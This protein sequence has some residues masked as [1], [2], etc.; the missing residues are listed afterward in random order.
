MAFLAVDLGSESVKAAIFARPKVESGSD[1]FLRREKKDC[2]E[3][4]GLGRAG[5]NSNEVYAGAVIDPE[6]VSEKTRQAIR[7]AVMA[8]GL[9]PK[10][11]IFG[12]SGEAVKGFTTK[13]RLNRGEPKKPLGD[14]EIKSIIENINRAVNREVV[15]EMSSLSA[16]SPAEN[17]YETI[18][19]EMEEVTVDNY[20]INNPV[21]C[22]GEVVE[23]SL[24]TA[25]S[26]RNYFENFNRLAK[27]VKISDY[28]SLPAL[29]PLVKFLYADGRGEMNFL[30]ID[31]GGQITDLA[32]VFGG[33]LISS[34]TIN[35]GGYL[36]TRSIAE[37]LG[38]SPE[39][40]AEKKS[41]Y[42]AGKLGE[43]E[44]QKISEI[45]RLTAKLWCS[46]IEA[47]LLDF[48]EVRSF[49]DRIFIVGGGSALSE[50]AGGLA[51][52]P[53]PRSIAF[54]AAPKIKQLGPEI[55]EETL[56]NRTG[57]SFSPSDLLPLSLGYHFFRLGDKNHV[58]NIF[59]L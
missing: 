36:F 3:V 28:K 8:C 34:R 4:L 10:Q 41:L 45:V 5:F 48:S 33:S 59:K 35:L 23:A 29:Y 56:V 9:S 50:I 57:K 52:H 20:K 38:I 58:R 7:E 53:W 17:N 30:I 16:K 6:T 54:A 47:A 51:D 22:T 25:V 40:A 14:K 55:L 11:L 21:G 2:L 1:D 15:K 18:Y 32:L 31:I 26:P 49:P 19:S 24:F 46:G 44:K 37:T 27:S 42:A 12:L 39:T 13:V 43:E